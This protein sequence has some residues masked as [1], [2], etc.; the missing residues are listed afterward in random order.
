MQPGWIIGAIQQ[1]FRDPQMVRPFWKQAQIGEKLY[2]ENTT[3]EERKKW[4][5]PSFFELNHF[6][7]HGHNPSYAARLIRDY[8]NHGPSV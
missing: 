1:L 5:L 4:R 7:A 8:A 6:G 3:P 2:F